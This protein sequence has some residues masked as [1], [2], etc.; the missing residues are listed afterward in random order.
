MRRRREPAF[1][2]DIRE[3][4]CCVLG[5]HGRAQVAHITSRGA[6]GSD[7]PDNVMPLCWKHH[8]EQ[9]ILGWSLFK[10][11]H[12]EVKSWLDLSGCPECRECEFNGRGSSEYP[13]CVNAFSMKYTYCP[14]YRVEF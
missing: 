13:A 10:R 11:R 5:C 7:D 14:G 12:P 3:Y 4:G 6:G 8:Q 2:A 9:H 1:F